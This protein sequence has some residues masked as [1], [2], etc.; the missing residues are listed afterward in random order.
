MAK[1][2]LSF[3]ENKTKVDLS[4][5]SKNQSLTWEDATMTWEDANGTWE[6]PLT[7]G[8][9]ETKTKDDLSLESK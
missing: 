8:T 7:P 9:L 4:K 2:D 1:V 5:E 6:N 3:N